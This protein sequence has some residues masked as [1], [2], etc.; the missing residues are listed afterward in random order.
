MRSLF[1]H[2]AEWR[3]ERATKTELINTVRLLSS[4]YSQNLPLSGSILLP[5]FPR[6]LGFLVAVL[7]EVS[8]ILYTFNALWIL[9][10]FLATAASLIP[11]LQIFSGLL[12]ALTWSTV[13]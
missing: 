11:V 1:P 9:I 5:Y 4:P 12:P 10:T 6:L 7:S 3:I 2:D 8:R 13:V